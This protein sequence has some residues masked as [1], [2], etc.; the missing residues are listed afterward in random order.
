M[1]E[2]EVN[3]FPPQSA[4]TQSDT[5]GQLSPDI[6]LALSTLGFAASIPTLDH[7]VRDDSGTDVD[8]IS[9][10]SSPAKHFVADGQLKTSAVAAPKVVAFV[11]CGDGLFASVVHDMIPLASSAMQA[12]AVRHATAAICPVDRV[13]GEDQLFPPR[14][15]DWAPDRAADPDDDPHAVRRPLS[16][17]AASNDPTPI[18]TRTGRPYLSAKRDV[19]VKTRCGRVGLST[20]SALGGSG[21]HGSWSKGWRSQAPSRR[22]RSVADPARIN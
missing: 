19:V 15:P 4:A 22:P 20:P 18:R 21:R 11:Q 6:V 13:A 3:E 14:L 9:P 17:A 8:N 2:V 10:F 16:I 5:L 7:E 1:G 12:A